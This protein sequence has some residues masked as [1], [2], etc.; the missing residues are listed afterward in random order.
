MQRS[1]RDDTV[2]LIWSK[3]ILPK[4]FGDGF[5]KNL[6][7]SEAHTS[8]FS[9]DVAIDQT[10]AWSEHRHIA[11]FQNFTAVAGTHVRCV[12]WQIRVEF[13]HAVRPY[14][15]MKKELLAEVDAYLTKFGWK[16]TTTDEGFLLIPLSMYIELEETHD[17][18]EKFWSIC[19]SVRGP[20][21]TD[22]DWGDNDFKSIVDADK[23]KLASHPPA[24]SDEQAAA[25]WAAGG[26][27]IG[28]RVRGGSNA[29]AGG[30]IA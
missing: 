14:I 2:R 22:L 15:F 16:F 30:S 1:R 28:R 19:K 20:S 3:S 27:H 10:I 25:A 12:P 6:V 24:V 18:Y 8:V 5:I 9:F 23:L 7:D 4:V 26:D 29:A 11:M 13:A 21:V 17:M